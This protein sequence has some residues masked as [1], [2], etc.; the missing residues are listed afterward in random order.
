MS[1]DIETIKDR[2]DIIDLIGQYV[3]LTKSGKNFRGL[4]PFHGEKTPSFFV[5]PELG[6]YKCF[7][8][9]ESGDIFTFIQKYENVSF[10]ESLEILAKRAGVE[11]SHA[12]QTKEDT[13]RKKLL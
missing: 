7:G 9:G 5:T 4:C 8:C 6:R 13:H 2:V 12:P 11:L 1:S 10:G 3:R